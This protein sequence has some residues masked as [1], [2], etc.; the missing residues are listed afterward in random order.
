VSESAAPTAAEQIS[1]LTF[2]CILL[3]PA[4][5]VREANQ[6]AEDLLGASLKRMAGHPFFDL[7]AFDDERIG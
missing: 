1:G 7:A 4:L 6:A 2:A 3:D 5:A